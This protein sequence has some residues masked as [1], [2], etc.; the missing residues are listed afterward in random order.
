MS[1]SLIVIHRSVNFYFTDVSEP[2]HI[3]IARSIF[4]LPSCQNRHRTSLAEEDI[5]IFTYNILATKLLCK[6][7]I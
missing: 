6:S 7:I 2:S 1:A 5:T 4:I 3:I